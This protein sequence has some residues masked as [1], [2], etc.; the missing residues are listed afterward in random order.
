MISCYTLFTCCIRFRVPGKTCADVQC[1]HGACQD[2]TVNGVVQFYCPCPK[3][4]SGF[5]CEKYLRCFSN[6][7]RCFATEYQKK[8]VVETDQFCQSLGEWSKPVLDNRATNWAFEIYLN[9]DPQRNLRS[10]YVWIGAQATTS[11]FANN[12]MW[13]WLDDTGNIQR[14]R[15]F[16]IK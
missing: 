5:F 12:N 6:T 7:G 16:Y 8:G 3:Y 9:E 1:E 2:I 15:C 10:G 4:M 11:N 13:K 14:Y